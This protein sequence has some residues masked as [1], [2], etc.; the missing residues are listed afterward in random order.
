VQLDA[1]VGIVVGGRV[2][3]HADL[4]LG[5]QLL[6]Q[7]APQARVERLA[8]VALAA[9]EFPR[10][11]QVR[12]VRSAGDEKCSVVLDD[13]CGDDDRFRQRRSDVNG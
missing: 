3:L 11:R 5:G 4:G 10:A 9:R 8:G 1:A 2:D 6:A 12:A 7:L 13:R